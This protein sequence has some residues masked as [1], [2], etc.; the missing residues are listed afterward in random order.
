MAP[1][2]FVTDLDNTLVG[3]DIALLTLNERLH[4]HRQDYGTRIVYSTGRSLTSY[5]RLQSKKPLLP[6]DAL[7]TGVGTAIHY[8]DPSTPD[9]E[10]QGE[11][12]SQWSAQLNQGWDRDQIQS[13]TAHFADLVPQPDTEQGRFKVSFYL[14]PDIAED[15]LP[16]LAARLKETG[17]S[18]NLIYSGSQDLDILPQSANKGTALNFLRQ[19]WQFA[20]QTTVVCGDSGNDQALFALGQTRGII[21]GNAMTEL[22]D[23][24]YQNPSGDRYLAEAACAGG[25]LEGLHHFGFLTTSG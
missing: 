11:P 14:S 1:F 2:L 25:I 19:Q 13:I 18:I 24:H 21:V 5:K 23:W 7:I 8:N 16:E 4:Q 17:L 3:D 15:V 10:W 9:L 12:D 22:L 20:P 6:P